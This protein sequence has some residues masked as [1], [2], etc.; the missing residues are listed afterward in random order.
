M[1]ICAMGETNI[2]ILGFLANPY[3]HTTSGV[4]LRLKQFLV[5][6]HKINY[7]LD[8][9]CFGALIFHAHLIPMSGSSRT[10]RTNIQGGLIEY[11]WYHIMT[12]DNTILLNLKYISIK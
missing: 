6:S 10:E 4:I 12:I 5:I 3:T 2:L 7:L 8:G 11:L 1:Y 9:S